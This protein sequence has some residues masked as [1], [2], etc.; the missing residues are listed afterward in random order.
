MNS[1]TKLGQI[2]G[3]SKVAGDFKQNPEAPISFK[4][5]KYL[6]AWVGHYN[7][8]KKAGLPDLTVWG[9][10]L[11]VGDMNSIKADITKAVGALPARDNSAMRE[12]KAEVINAAKDMKEAL[13]TIAKLKSVIG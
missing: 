10:E 4:Q 6:A 1:L 2:T 12:K 13:A 3:G 11:T 8:N 5:R 9:V 7:K